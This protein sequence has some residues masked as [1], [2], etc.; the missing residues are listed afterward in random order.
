MLVGSVGSSGPAPR[1]PVRLAADKHV[2]V[3]PAPTGAPV[4][5]P[6]VANE[7]EAAG[8]WRSGVTRRAAVTESANVEGAATSTRPPLTLGAKALTRRSVPVRSSSETRDDTPARAADAETGD[9]GP[10]LPQGIGVNVAG[11]EGP[12]LT[13]P[14]D[15]PYVPPDSMG[16]VGPQQ[17]LLAL[18]GRIRTFT[19][20]GAQDGVLDTT[21][22]LFFEDATCVCDPHVRYD[23]HSDR[24]FVVAIDHCVTGTAD[25][26]VLIAVSDDDVITAAGWSFYT[27]PADA[28]TF[29]D[30]PTLGIDED[31]LYV[32]TNVFEESKEFEGFFLISDSHGYVVNKPSLLSGGP[33]VFTKFAN[34]FDPATFV[35]LISPQGV[36]NFDTGTNQGYFIAIDG[37]SPGQLDLRRVSNPGSTPGVSARI[38]ISTDDM[39]LP[40]DVPQPAGGPELD[41]LP[42]V[43]LSNAIIR[44]GRLWTS[45]SIGVDSSGTVPPIAEPDR[46]GARWY[47]LQNLSTTPSVAQS[48]TV[49][50]SAGTNPLSYWMA[51]V[52]VSGQGHTA[53]G[54]SRAGTHATNGFASASTAGRLRTDA[55]GTTRTPTLIQ[56]STFLY[57]PASDPFEPKRWGDYSATSLDPTDDM[58]MWTVQE[59]ASATD[60]W[61]V[62]IAE[63]KAPPPTI[64]GGV[65]PPDTPSASVSIVG[66]GFFEPGD[67]FP[68]HL[69]V[70][71]EA[72]S[73]VVL[74]D[75]TSV[76]PS[77][78]V[79]GLD[80][81][82]V[83]AGEYDVTVTNPDGQRATGTLTVSDTTPEVTV[84]PQTLAFGDLIIGQTS[85]T[86]TVTVANS[87]T[88]PLGVGDVELGTAPTDFV[89]G[90]DTCSGESLAAAEMCSVQVTFQPE[91]LGPKTATLSIP[92]TASTEPEIVTLSGTGIAAPA[93]P[94]P[95]PT[96]TPL[97][98]TLTVT[99]SPLIAG[100]VAT[101]EGKNFPALAP[102][103]LVLRSEPVRVASAVT[104]ETGSLAA[105]FTIPANTSAGA[106]TLEA[107]RVGSSAVLASVAMTIQRES[108]VLATSTQQPTRL[109]ATG[110]DIAEMARAGILLLVLG[111]GLLAVSRRRVSRP[112]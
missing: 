110:T 106:H 102:I 71:F 68:N 70:E 29:N 42:A 21:L 99:S 61:G 72:S 36:D 92:T 33:V 103:S 7:L 39:A 43:F 108:T 3:A 10:H 90:A 44:D 94:T 9:V 49:F 86:K 58:T 48:G 40:T 112:R 14:D 55:A 28:G 59:Y 91:S 19:K 83:A 64:S 47:E 45:H 18:N 73:G 88:V 82:G 23:R 16:A 95:T 46:N 13:P 89:I 30:F 15:S 105:S 66:T 50:D 51:S 54:F 27:I 81:T 80:T 67:E 26:Q 63:L 69:E 56:S 98:P 34:L 6:V 65:A 22:E 38:E 12:G 62:R 75:I 74:N 93:T 20:A 104:G 41:A 5:R 97:R 100:H 101:V 8:G 35:G 25:N 96:A 77:Q 52:M 109:P 17:F 79:V 87:G 107:R 37:A 76:T 111:A 24:W 53:L 1:L 85:T 78:V 60:K 11:A 32:G 57:D 84:S 31:A 4:P 2:G